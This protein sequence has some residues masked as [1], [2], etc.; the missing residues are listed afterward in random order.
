VVVFGFLGELVFRKEFLNAVLVKCNR[1]IVA[2]HVATV[3]II[4][5]L[6][7]FAIA[8][9]IIFKEMC[10]LD[11]W[12]GT[13]VNNTRDVL[14]E[15]EV[16]FHIGGITGFVEMLWAEIVTIDTNGTSSECE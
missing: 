10:K 7:E 12:A 8:T 16:S 1:M 9:T 2:G 4:V 15:T 5:V 11:D 13:G 3:L 14:I 6:D